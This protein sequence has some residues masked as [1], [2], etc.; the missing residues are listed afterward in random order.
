MVAVRVG[1]AGG[2]EPV[3]RHALAVVRRGQQAIDDLLVGVGRC[4]GEEG[5]DLGRRRRQAGQ[6]E[7]H[8]ADERAS[9][10]PRRDGLQA[11]LLPA[12]RG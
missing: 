4:V 9:D 7:R 10:R 8:A 12:G 6:V 11:L 2:V 3:D 5:I 1:V